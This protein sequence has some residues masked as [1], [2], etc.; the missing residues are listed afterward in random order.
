MRQSRKIDIFESYEKMRGIDPKLT[1]RLPLSMYDMTVIAPTTSSHETK[2][3]K[4]VRKYD[5]EYLKLGFTTKTQWIH[6]LN[7]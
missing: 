2:R 3:R 4:V 5:I 6:V 7:A 1:E